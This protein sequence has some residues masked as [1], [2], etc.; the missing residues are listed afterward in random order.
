[1]FITIVKFEFVNREIVLAY[2]DTKQEAEQA[3]TDIETNG[4]DFPKCYGVLKQV[5]IFEIK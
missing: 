5:K 3:A 4:G 1:M 2:T